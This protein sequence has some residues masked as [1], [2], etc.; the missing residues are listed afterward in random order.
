MTEPGMTIAE[1][2]AG[3]LHNS[4]KLLFTQIKPAGLFQRLCVFGAETLLLSFES[5][6][7]QRRVLLAPAPVNI[8]VTRLRV[9]GR[10]RR[11]EHL[12]C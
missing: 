7:A 10:E 4:G 2:R 11:G 5:V 6:G 9:Q 1:E 8:T 12:C 3:W